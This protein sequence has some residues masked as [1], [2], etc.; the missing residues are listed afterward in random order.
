MDS[1]EWNQ[2]N[3]SIVSLSK[4]LRDC[5]QSLV[6]PRRA[7]NI[8]GAAPEE[9]HVVVVVGGGGTRQQNQAFTSFQTCF[10]KLMICPSRCFEQLTRHPSSFIFY[11][12]LLCKKHLKKVAE[13]EFFR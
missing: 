9:G 10:S 11:L 2:S 4:C 5:Q 6:L 3:S 12:T 1:T 8:V 13:Y 7:P